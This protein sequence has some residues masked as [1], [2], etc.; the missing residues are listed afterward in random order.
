MRTIVL[1]AVAALLAG[2][3]FAQADAPPPAWSGVWKGTLGEAQ[4]VAC[5]G[6][7]SDP[8]AGAYYYVSHLKLIGLDPS[9]APPQMWAEGSIGDK[10]AA[11]WTLSPSGDAM[12]GTWSGSGKSLPIR[13]TRVP[14]TKDD[15]DTPCGA[16]AF[17]QP[18]VPTPT[19]SRK[20]A[21]LDGVAYTK[22]IVNTGAD[23]DVTLETFA[24]D[25]STPAAARINAVLAKSLP[26]AG[27][28]GDYVYCLTGAAGSMGGDGV[29]TDTLEPVLI[30][31][32]WMATEDDTENACGGAHP[33][34]ETDY[35]LYD[36]TSGAAVEP[37]SW[38]TADGVTHSSDSPDTPEVGP[39]LRKML[40]ARW[41]RKGDCK[42]VLD[43]NDF[44]DIHP[45]RT[46]LA[47]WPQL[48]HV[49]AACSQDVTIPYAAL[50]PLLN[51]KGKVAIASIVDDVK[52]LPPPA[53][54]HK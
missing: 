26:K 46:G 11:R 41:T 1:A 7:E 50:A 27:K 51:A 15:A 29:Y 10:K 19:V 44:W 12:T 39:K 18:R 30:S 35:H 25:A 43:G 20:P 31:K 2:A 9:T 53:A 32:R 21:M 13:L 6:T 34:E 22:L 17:T 4:V 23:L 45:T 37:W 5:F 40:V 33:D 52:A 38:F 24:L 47:F 16:W 36:M 3:A 28:P 42:D 8:S 54:K 14:L 49:V 48:P